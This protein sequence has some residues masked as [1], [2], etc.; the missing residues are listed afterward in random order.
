MCSLGS[1][2][3]FFLEEVINR[4]IALT[5]AQGDA[6]DEKVGVIAVLFVGTHTRKICFYLLVTQS[7]FR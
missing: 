4:I 6:I 3:F 7:V 5:K 1:F 2:F